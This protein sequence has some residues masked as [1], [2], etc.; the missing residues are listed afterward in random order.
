MGNEGCGKGKWDGEKVGRRGG[1]GKGR[2]WG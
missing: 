2:R 1:E